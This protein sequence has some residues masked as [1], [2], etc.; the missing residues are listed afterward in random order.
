MLPDLRNPIIIFMLQ[1][2]QVLTARM[3]GFYSRPN[4]M[5]PFRVTVLEVMRI[6][7][8]LQRS[9]SKAQLQ[10]MFEGFFSLT[11]GWE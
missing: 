8:Q 9:N 5:R 2:I 11:L 6:T 3:E 7:H 1:L 4:W 10:L